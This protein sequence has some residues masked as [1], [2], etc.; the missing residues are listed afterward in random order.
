MSQ[1]PEDLV[2]AAEEAFN[3]RE[4]EAMVALV[5]PEIEWETGLPGTPTYQGREGVR[6]LF[7]D[8][9]TAWD[10]LAVRANLETLRGEVMVVHWRMKGRGITSGATFEQS[11]YVAVEFRDGLA[12]HMRAFQTATEA[13]EA[14]GF[15]E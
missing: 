3:R 4:I 9:E 8:I 15:S 7:R 6:Q 2:R 13:L 14:A 1:E 11:Q 10:D 5:H 12:I